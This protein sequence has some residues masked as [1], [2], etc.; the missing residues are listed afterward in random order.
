MVAWVI[1]L[2]MLGLIV[3]AF[4][5]GRQL[6][7]HDSVH[8]RERETMLEQRR[9]L[10]DRLYQE[11]AEARSGSVTAA[12]EV[13]GGE[14]AEGELSLAG[15]EAFE[16]L[17]NLLPQ[18]P[19]DEQWQLLHK[20]CDLLQQRYAGQRLEPPPPLLRN[21]LGLL[22]S[23]PESYR[24]QGPQREGLKLEQLLLPGLSFE[25]LNLRGAK[26]KGCGF[27]GANLQGLDLFAASGEKLDFSSAELTGANLTG[28]SLSGSDF[29]QARLGKAELITAELVDC[30]LA[31][32][33]LSGAALRGLR[34]SGCDLRGAN[35]TEATGLTFKQLAGCRVDAKTRLP[36]NLLERRDELLARSPAT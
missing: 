20:L 1:V 6:K 19:G 35:L 13:L 5:H 16:T 32:A 31:E 22:S 29:R 3:W 11:R 28:I 36:A 25:K 4:W 23:R 34:L 10:E 17:R 15:S 2:A 18:L 24:K 12:L 21:L 9:N 33:D 30:C 7:K 8:E 26:L 27:A 14:T